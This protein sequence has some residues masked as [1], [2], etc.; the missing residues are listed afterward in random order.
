[1][2]EQHM[3]RPSRKSMLSEINHIMLRGIGHMDLFTDESDYQFF[4]ST[5][6]RLMD[7]TEITIYS[8]CLMS[9]HVHLLL[10]ASP[11]DIPV[12]FQSLE[13]SYAR[14]FNDIYGHIGH[15]FQNR[16]KSEAI[17]DNA[18]FLNALRYILQ[19][20]EKAGICAW[21]AYPWSS[22]GCYRSQID[23][24]ITDTSIPLAMLSGRES[25]LRFMKS[26]SDGTDFPL[27]EPVQGRKGISDFSARLILKRISGLENPLQL[28][29]IDR[30]ERD[31]VLCQLK[32]EGMTIR[33]LERMTG[34]NRST[35]QRAKS[36]L[37]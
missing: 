4:L 29:E 6:A 23:D 27:A 7:K 33:Q 32:Q 20:P 31:K 21:D 36:K 25:F 13:I 19:N 26:S 30:K 5:L 15:V 28:Q 1:M 34:I 35:I 9:N 17:K 2:E 8:Y 22:A 14:H 11:K 24:E 10:K 18:H 3:T 37:G 16:Y 12:F